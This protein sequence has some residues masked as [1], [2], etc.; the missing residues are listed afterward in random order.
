[1]TRLTA[2]FEK[3]FKRDVRIEGAFDLEADAFSVTVLFGPSGCGKTT[4][5]RC[6]AGLERP[7]RGIIRVGDAVW[8][9]GTQNLYLPPQ[10]R[11][12]GY[13]SQ[14]YSLFPHLNVAENIA[15]GLKNRSKKEIDARVK[16][17]LSALHLEGLAQ[18]RPSE[19]SG[20]QQ[21][22]V[23]LAR[24]TARQPGLVLLDEPLS[25]LDAPTRETIRRDLRLW[26]ARFKAPAIVV[27]HDRVEALALADQVVVMDQGKIQ[28][29]G[30]IA[31]VFSRPSNVHVARII[32]TETVTPGLVKTVVDGLA[33]VAM[34]SSTVTAMADNIG[35]GEQVFVCIRGEDVLLQADRPERMS[36]RNC[37]AGSILS[38]VP[39]GP[40]SRVRI[41]CG[42]ELTALVTRPAIE[43]LALRPGAKVVALLKAQSIHLIPRGQPNG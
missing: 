38:V 20:G 18:R 31:E 1:M 2:D 15:F 37:L 5:L 8:F 4:V 23:A 11:N 40:L 7:D 16:D 34:G 36:A 27:T 6:L 24:A 25:A 9:D 10:K 29:S 32:G 19:L 12:L 42:F 3:D 26:L 22:R 17:Q 28:Q 13:L 14:D 39:E 41:A 21:Q 33:T 35:V 43:E 30:P